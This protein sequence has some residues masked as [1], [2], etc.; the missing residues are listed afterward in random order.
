MIAYAAQADD[1]S[2]LLEIIREILGTLVPI[3]VGLALVVFL[4]GVLRYV[5]AGADKE[6]KEQG[7]N[8]MI[9]GIIGLTVMVSIWGLVALVKNTFFESSPAPFE[10]D[11]GQQDDPGPGGGLI[12]V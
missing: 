2:G 9:W 4:W 5:I 1:L 11:D 7:R 3:I 6:G 8:F 10:I 12:E